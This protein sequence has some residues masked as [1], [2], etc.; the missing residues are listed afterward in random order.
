MACHYE[1]DGVTAAK[2]EN[3]K[4]YPAS[5][6]SLRVPLSMTLGQDLFYGHKLNVSF[7]KITSCPR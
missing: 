5:E 4:K 1:R 2:V 7:A 6:E 3:V